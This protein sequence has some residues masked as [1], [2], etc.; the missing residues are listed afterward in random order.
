MRLFKILLLSLLILFTIFSYSFSI[1][2]KDSRGKLIKLPSVPKRIVSLAPSNTEILYSL[3]LGQRIA[4][5]TRFCNY[6]PAAK[7]KPKVGDV[8]MSIEA[9]ARL[10]PDL[11]LAH[12]TLHDNIIP[13][14]EKL[15]IKVFAVDPGTID[16]TI[17]AILS[18]GAITNTSAKAAVV[19]SNMKSR[20]K[21]VVKNFHPKKKRSIL[22]SIQSNPLWVAGPKTIPNDILAKLK[23]KNIA[24]DA[25]PGYVTFSTELAITRNPDL[26]VVGTKADAKYFMSSSIWKTTS[27]VRNKRVIVIDPDMLVRPGPRIIDGMKAIAAKMQF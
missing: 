2:A 19:A 12:A 22:I 6:P 24:H 16:Q 25:R 10:K 9:I 7:L 5:V 15:G 21:S 14:L 11:V 13:K 23:I 8:S 27:A 1:Q 17:S 26:I 4:G 20:M 18:I 3:G